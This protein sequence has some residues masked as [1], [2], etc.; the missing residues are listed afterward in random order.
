MSKPT[1]P[2]KCFRCTI[3]LKG[4]AVYVAGVN[5]A[6]CHACAISVCFMKGKVTK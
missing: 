5:Q 1:I 2:L 3:P 6:M 4:T